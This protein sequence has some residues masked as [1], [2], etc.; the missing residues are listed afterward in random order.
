MPQ[1]PLQ[2]DVALNPLN[3]FGPLRTDATGNLRTSSGISQNYNITAATVIKASAGRAVKVSVI[4]AGSGVGSVNDCLTTGAVAVGNQ[5]A[6]VPETVGVIN[7]D[8]PCATGIVL[9]PGTGQTLA[10]AWV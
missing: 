8:W 1:S 7:L 2:A 5:V 9:V 3:A 6:V 10:I 4:V